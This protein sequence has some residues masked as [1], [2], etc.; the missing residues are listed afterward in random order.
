ML[1]EL[2]WNSGARRKGTAQRH[3]CP[4]PAPSSASRPEAACGARDRLCEP[5]RD[6]RQAP[7]AATAALRPP[8]LAP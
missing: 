1:E 3:L 8:A 2:N 4:Y 7:R 6:T 5:Q